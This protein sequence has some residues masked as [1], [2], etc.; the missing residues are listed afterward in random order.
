MF[1]LSLFAAL[2][3]S[4][5][6][7]GEPSPSK[8]STTQETLPKAKDLETTLKAPANKED[9]IQTV[10]T[11]ASLKEENKKNRKWSAGFKHSGTQG[12]Y[13]DESRT[14][15]SNSLS[16][17]YRLSEKNSISFKGAYFSPLIKV[18]NTSPYGLTDVSMTGSF[19][20]G[21]LKDFL[22]FQWA[23]SAGIG[24]PTS[25]KSYRAGKYGSLFGS[26]DHNLKIH[27]KISLSLSHLLYAG[28]YKYQSNSIGIPNRLASSSHTGSLVFKHGALT[29]SGTVVL[30]FYFHLSD[31][32]KD[33][34][35]LDTKWNF[36]GVQGWSLDA[37]FLLW[38]KYKVQLSGGLSANIPVISSVLESFPFFKKRYQSYSLG[39]SW[40]F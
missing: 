27:K 38:P 11:E 21:F 20:L 19:P 10:K 24:L 13:L 4:F 39:L 35:I 36:K 6:S 1:L 9:R 14:V 32:E 15:V 7:Y 29:L 34:E 31:R 23:G 25:T 2:S 33:P 16:I 3:F 22:G 40:G 30:F 37:S 12:S 18:S 26:L 8:E 17:S 28:F 5:F